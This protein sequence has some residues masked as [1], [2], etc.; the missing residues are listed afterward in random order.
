[1]PKASSV[2][3]VRIGKKMPIIIDQERKKWS[4]EKI[5]KFNAQDYFESH[6]ND[7]QQ[8]L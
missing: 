4:D 8:G 3:M 5:S 1:M 7:V 6:D 2:S